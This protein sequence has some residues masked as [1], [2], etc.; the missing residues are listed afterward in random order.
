MPWV[1]WRG[2][3]FPRP[4]CLSSMWSQGCPG[5]SRPSL[6]HWVEQGCAR[7][8]GQGRRMAE[9]PLTGVPVLAR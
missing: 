9:W 2:A 7:V 8:G 5:V 6:T 4:G 1:G 3:S